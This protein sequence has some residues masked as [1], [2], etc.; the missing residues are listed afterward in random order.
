MAR[1]DVRSSGEYVVLRED[2]IDEPSAN[3]LIVLQALRASFD[4][5]DSGH[6]SFQGI[7]RKLGMHQET[8]SRSLQ[9]LERD[10][11][12]VKETK[13]YAISQKGEQIISRR[14]KIA[15]DHSEAYSIPI[16]RTMLPL[17]TDPSSLEASLSHKWF[18][19]LR[20]FGSSR[21]EDGSILT[22][23][24]QDGKMRLNTKISDGYITIECEAISATAMSEAVKAAYAIFHQVSEA[25]RQSAL[26]VRPDSYRAA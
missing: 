20:W 21:S 22:W 14:S 7:K 4:E 17:D 3:D 1:D 6:I 16:L 11:F 2:D 13:E 23:I 25:V 9:R 24:T 26:R 8:L 18:G 10:G 15:P 19:N 12:V 5:A